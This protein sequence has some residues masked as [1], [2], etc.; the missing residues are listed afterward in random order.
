MKK[1]LF[2]S[3]RHSVFVATTSWPLLFPHNLCPDSFSKELTSLIILFSGE[4][5]MG[6]PNQLYCCVSVATPSSMLYLSCKVKKVCIL[7]GGILMAKPHTVIRKAS[8]TRELT[9]N[10]QITTTGKEGEKVGRRVFNEGLLSVL[11]ARG[12][13]KCVLPWGR[14]A[15]EPSVLQDTFF[16]N[17]GGWGGVGVRD[18]VGGTWEWGYG[19]VSFQPVR[20]KVLYLCYFI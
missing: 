17:P 7:L 4:R 9:R 5:E 6:N 2:G 10:A 3:E 12:T 8:N 16:F 15:G 13:S 18:V 20:W 1:C 14:Q 11:E 19:F